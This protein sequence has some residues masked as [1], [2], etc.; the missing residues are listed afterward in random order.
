[1]ATAFC[2]WSYCHLKGIYTWTVC[3]FWLDLTLLSVILFYLILLSYLICLQNI[4]FQQNYSGF[5]KTWI[6]VSWNKFSSPLSYSFRQKNSRY[7]ESQH[8]KHLAIANKVF[9]SMNDFILLYLTTVKIYTLRSYV[10]MGIKA[11]RSLNRQILTFSRDYF[12][13]SA[14]SKIFADKQSQNSSWFLLQEKCF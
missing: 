2:Q 13:R 10:V 1:M 7:L 3:C 8:F 9:D 12:R 4:C 5:S 14:T 6:L 11:R